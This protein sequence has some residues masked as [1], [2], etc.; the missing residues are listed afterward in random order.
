MGPWGWLCLCLLV[1]L[2]QGEEEVSTTTAEPAWLGRDC[3][4]NEDGELARGPLGI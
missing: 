4:R 2:A 1:P 3:V